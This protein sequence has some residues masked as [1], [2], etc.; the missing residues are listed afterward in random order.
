MRQKCGKIKQKWGEIAKI[1]SK[2]KQSGNG[3]RLAWEMLAGNKPAG[4]FCSRAAFPTWASFPGF[5][6]DADR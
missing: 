1:L 4:S 5:L 2:A 3:T 6:K